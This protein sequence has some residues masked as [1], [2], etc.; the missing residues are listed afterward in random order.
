MESDQNDFHPTD[1]IE[2]ADGSLLVANTGS[3]YHICCP[4][5]KLSKPQILGA[6]YRIQKMNHTAIEDP[7]GFK[8]DWKN[9][10]VDFLSD[11]RSAVVN[12]AID[13]LAIEA[14]VKALRSADARLP[15]T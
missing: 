12:R 4:T 11:T 14:N 15:A 9:P 1:V 10:D 5:S 7:R 6:V 13:A 2:D 3:W 8:L